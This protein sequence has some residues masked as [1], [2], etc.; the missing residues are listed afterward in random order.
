MPISEQMNRLILEGANVGK[1]A[2]QSR[3]EGI[4]DLRLSGLRKA[5]AGI[6]SLAEIDRV[7]RE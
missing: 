4:A 1:I 2:D 6:T 7:T 5:K 3:Q